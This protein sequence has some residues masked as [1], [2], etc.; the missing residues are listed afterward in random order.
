MRSKPLWLAT[1][2]RFRS[3]PRAKI[4]ICKR[5]IRHPHLILQPQ[6]ENTKRQ[7]LTSFKLSP[8][9]SQN[10]TS[11]SFFPHK[12]THADPFLSQ[13]PIVLL[14]LCLALS[15]PR[16]ATP[17]P[18]A[19]HRP[20][21]SQKKKDRRE[22]RAL[23]FRPFAGHVAPGSESSPDLAHWKIPPNKAHTPS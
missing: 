3:S 12:H 22:G 19:P 21:Q 5:S 9:L 1:R 20:R 15:Q 8:I 2:Q 4:Y 16:T 10:A 6:K 7:Y 11:L 18:A 14:A 23:R 13:Q 17:T